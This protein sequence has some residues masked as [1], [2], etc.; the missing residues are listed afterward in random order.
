MNEFDKIN[1]MIK[2][3]RRANIIRAVS[4]FV[5]SIIWTTSIVIAKGFWSTFFVIFCPPYTAYVVVEHFLKL[6]KLI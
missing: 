6:Y 5:G 4:M 1:Y 3:H 2:L